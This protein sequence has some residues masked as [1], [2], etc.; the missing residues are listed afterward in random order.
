MKAYKSL[1]ILITVGCLVFACVSLSG[2]NRA[3]SSGPGQIAIQNTKAITAEDVVT[4]LGL[5]L[6][7]FHIQWPREEGVRVKLWV[8]EYLQK[9]GSIEHQTHYLGALSDPSPTDKM[10]VLFPESGRKEYGFYLGGGGTRYTLDQIRM[11]YGTGQVMNVADQLRVEYGSTFMLAVRIYS[12][13]GSAGGD[14]RPAF[15]KANL[16]RENFKAILVFKAQFDPIPR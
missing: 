6:Y 3:T 14:S 11:D 8:E 5:P 16:R 12:E 13:K 15:L 4:A 1:L 7:K 10:L 9:E 2:C